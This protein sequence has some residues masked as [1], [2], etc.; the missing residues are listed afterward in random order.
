MEERDSGLAEAIRKYLNYIKGKGQP[1]ILT[2]SLKE[3]LGP[4]K[5]STGTNKRTKINVKLFMTCMVINGD[6]CSKIISIYPQMLEKVY[7]MAKFRPPRTYKT[8]LWYLFGPSGIGKTTTVFN[9]LTAIRQTHP[10]VNLEDYQSFGMVMI[11]SL[12]VGLMI[13]LHL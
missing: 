4:T 7:K 12:F 1:W 13:L 6:R 9:T 3:Y 11:I 2:G 5:A 10:V 8:D